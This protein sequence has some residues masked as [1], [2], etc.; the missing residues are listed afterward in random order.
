MVVIETTTLTRSASVA[1]PPISRRK[2]AAQPPVR[3]ARGSLG[4]YVQ[5][6]GVDELMRELLMRT[7]VEEPAS[8]A[9][10][11]SGVCAELAAVP[12]PVREPPKPIVLLVGG[13]GSGRSVQGAPLAAALGLTR[14]TEDDLL[15]DELARQT[16]LGYEVAD[17]LKKGKIVP[18]SLT[19]RLFAN[20][21]EAT[22]GPWLFDGWPRRL[23]SFQ[24]LEAELGRVA[25]AV[26]LR[27][28]PEVVEWRIEGRDGAHA[29]FFDAKQRSMSAEGM[30]MRSQAF[31]FGATP[32]LA[33]LAHD[34]RMV[35]VDASG[36]NLM[37]TAAVAADA[38]RRV[39]GTDVV[40][41]AA[42]GGEGGGGADAELSLGFAAAGGET[43]WLPIPIDGIDSTDG[44]SPSSSAPAANKPKPKKSVAPRAKWVGFDVVG[45]GLASAKAA[46]GA[47]VGAAAARRL[48]TS[49]DVCVCV[50]LIAVSAA[51]ASL[52]PRLQLGAASVWDSG[53]VGALTGTVTPP[54]LVDA[55]V[56]WVRLGDTAR[57]KLFLAEDD[58]PSLA[59]KAALALEGGLGVCL[60]LPLPAAA[61]A[62][63]AG[64]DAG[65]AAA[66]A[67]ADAKAALMEALKPL[68][69]EVRK[70]ACKTPW[71][72][73][74]LACHPPPPPYANATGTSTDAGGAVDAAAVQAALACV[75]ACVAEAASSAAAAAVRVVLAVDAGAAAGG[76]EGAIVGAA[77]LPDVDGLL[78]RCAGAG[79]EAEAEAEE[80]I[81]AVELSF[82]RPPK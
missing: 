33:H 51:D 76:A 12:K 4:D 5:R 82:S 48:P 81:A 50:P 70:A 46:V 9:A 72:K 42:A 59:K 62:L 31:E 53:G 58:A 8:P 18:P 80:A 13:P 23:D 36:A 30:A 1:L 37:R 26:H 17:H 52:P 2:A 25:L 40:A 32:L 65:G 60:S 77:T 64:G 35:E 79:A 44:G 22:S 41:A 28:A 73:L 57:R 24:A 27:A 54:M 47:V 55:G 45:G 10:F 11:L 34:E 74:V 61:M 67:A 6:T 3:H 75:R 63:A 71:A 15:Q 43:V 29:A 66:A 20:G 39:L 7:L 21:M 78:C 38:V 14:L 68:C 16:D 69:V 56:A 49:H 19:L